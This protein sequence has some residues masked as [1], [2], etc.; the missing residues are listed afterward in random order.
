MKQRTILIIEDDSELAEVIGHK[1]QNAGFATLIT[2]SGLDGAQL[3]ESEQ[4]D[5]ILLDLALPDIDGIDILRHLRQRS[6]VPVVIVSGR[7]EEAERVVGLELGADDYMA[8]PFSLNE[9]VARVRVILR[10]AEGSLV[11]AP[12]AGTARAESA[13]EPAAS[14]PEELSA[15]DIE[16]NI[17]ARRAWV[18]GQELSL[19][20]TEF[21]I[22]QTLLENQGKVVSHKAL[23]EAAWGPQEEDTHLVEVHMVNLRAK[24]ETDPKSP[25][26][27][28][29]VRGFGYR[30]G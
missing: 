22:L 4:P 15:L 29:T 1:L 8:K 2:T 9:L 27:I 13:E 18:A 26:R 12:L 23:L 20:P 25:Q 14:E 16:M 24:I 7:T 21:I 6:A 30:L 10:R 17:A 11:E 5:L 3:A 19:T 28:K